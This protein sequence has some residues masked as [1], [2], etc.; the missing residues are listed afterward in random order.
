MRPAAIV[1]EL[2]FS[3]LPVCFETIPAEEPLTWPIVVIVSL[4]ALTP[5]PAPPTSPVL[6][7]ARKWWTLWRELRYCELVISNCEHIEPGLEISSPRNCN[8]VTVSDEAC[9]IWNAARSKTLFAVLHQN[10]FPFRFQRTR[11]STK[12]HRVWCKADLAP[13]LILISISI[14]ILESLMRAKAII[15]SANYL[16]IETEDRQSRLHRRLHQASPCSS[17]FTRFDSRL[18][19]VESADRIYMCAVLST[20]SRSFRVRCAG[21]P[22]TFHQR[23]LKT[24]S[25]NGPRAI[26]AIADRCTRVLCD[27]IANRAEFCSCS[28]NVNESRHLRGRLDQSWNYYAPISKWLRT[29]NREEINSSVTIRIVRINQTDIEWWSLSGSDSMHI[30]CKIYAP[31][32]SRSLDAWSIGRSTFP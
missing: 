24:S 13:R 6:S 21:S 5:S 25:Y 16:L 19:R 2:A 27:T 26:A 29:W 23:S 30:C 22:C 15:R 4:F 8:S 10:Y 18:R 12:Q 28:N 17:L 3:T 32:G 11:C 31:N 14:I 7:G 1:T 20:L 9:K